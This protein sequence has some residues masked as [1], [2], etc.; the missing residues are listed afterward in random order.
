M[1]YEKVLKTIKEHNLLS[2]GETVICAVSGG[3]DSMCLLTVM[4]AL[5]AEMRLRVVAANLNH[6]LRG[7]EGD[8]DSQYVETIC[9][10]RGIP[11][12]G[13]KLDVA[14]IAHA[15][16]QSIEEAGRE[17]RYKFFQE[18][19]AKLGGA[20]IATGHN[21][22]DNAETILFRLARGSA[23][24]GLCG[25]QYKRGNIIRPLLDASRGEIRDYLVENA[26]LWR[27]DSSNA[28]LNYTR[29]KIRH[30]VIPRLEEINPEAVEKIAGFGKSLSED[31]EYL[32]G[33]ADKLLES[34]R[35]EKDE[36]STASIL[37]APLPI[38]KRAAAKLLE[39]WG[40]KD[41]DRDKV[42][43][44]LA[45]C[46]KP[47]GR[48]MDINADVYALRSF[49]TIVRQ[50]RKRE[51]EFSYI[52]RAGQKVCHE[53]WE[54]SIE[55]TSS[56]P[57]SDSSTAVFDAAQLFGLFTVRS[58]R[59]GD[60]IK[61]KGCDGNKKLKDLFTEMKIPLTARG[62]VPVIAKGDEIVFVPPLRKTP[63]YAPN[64]N[65]K[66]FLVIQY[67]D[68]NSKGDD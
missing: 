50:D 53:G 31:E 21:L 3:A 14:A 9:E 12:Y 17:E 26:V 60:K 28:E 42:S 5:S 34:A 55:V 63:R 39:M 2:G 7:A 1:L 15:R 25:I 61:M 64:E 43:S 54:V 37:G 38:A 29:N 8:G 11:F 52:I 66:S 24:R 33:L 20:V 30:T 48:Q 19:S 23:P 46:S 57:P 59:D 49:Y 56:P 58:R 16:G 51:R 10:I 62:L 13:K 36:Y 41:I 47:S 27:E 40:A 32:G 4:K 67:T 22:G 65:T 35:V 6:S 18:V 68:K 44:L 45:L